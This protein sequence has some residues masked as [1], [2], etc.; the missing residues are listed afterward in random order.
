MERVSATLRSLLLPALLWA[1]A[2]GQDITLPET[3]PDPQASQPAGAGVRERSPELYYIEDAAGRLVPVP[4]FRYRDFMELFR[5]KEGLGA[6]A[7]PPPAF[8]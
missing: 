2:A 6:P 8:R 7:L 1:A 4:G 3:A 5:I